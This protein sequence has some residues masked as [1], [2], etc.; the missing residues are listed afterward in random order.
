LED[1]QPDTDVGTAAFAELDTESDENVVNL[2][3]VLLKDLSYS[4][5]ATIIHIASQVVEEMICKFVD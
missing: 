2:K 5:Y 4:A 1:E 3:D